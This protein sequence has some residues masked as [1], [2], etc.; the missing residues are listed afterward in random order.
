MNA[1]EAISDFVAFMEANDVVP[2]EPIASRLGSGD[3]IR[4]QCEG[5]KKGRKNGWAILHLDARPAGAFGNHRLNT[6]TLKWKANANGPAL[7]PEEREALQREWKAAKEKREAERHSNHIQA[8]LD[9][10]EIWN[11]A[12]P[13]ILHDYLDAKDIDGDDLRVDGENLLV[14]MFDKG[15]KLWN[16]QRIKPDGQKRFLHGGRIDDLFCLIGSPDKRGMD[17]VIV[18]GYATGATVHAATG[19]PVI[20]SFNTSNLRRVA[21]LW[22]EMR[23]DLQFTIFA[24]DDEATALRELERTGEHKNPGIEIA[25]SVASE[26][27]AAVAY[28]LGRPQGEAA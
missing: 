7:S 15:G 2:A 19:L 12:R 27:G 23:A 28:P 21:R 20:V 26:I 6:G 5:D 14:P 10:A 11:R 3:M 16:L 13:A 24:D 17:A 25:R 8:A 18:E 22:A 9:A 4:F 1:H